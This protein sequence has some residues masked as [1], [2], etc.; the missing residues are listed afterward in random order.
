MNKPKFYILKDKSPVAID[1]GLEWGKW[2]ETADRTVKKT[3]VADVEIST[4]FLGLDHQ[5]FNGPPLLFETMVIGGESDQDCT[6][7]STW[8]E[9]KKQHKD[10]V[11]KITALET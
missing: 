6:R 3:T 4:V 2:F 10:M 5:H 8:D 7:C 1:D 9:A 11:Y